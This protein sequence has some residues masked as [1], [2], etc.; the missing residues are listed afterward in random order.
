MIYSKL[1]VDWKITK[2]YDY[3]EIETEAHKFLAR[4]K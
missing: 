1:K 3:K 2:K 4:Y